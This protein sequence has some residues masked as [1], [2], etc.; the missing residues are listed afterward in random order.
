M[1]RPRRLLPPRDQPPVRDPERAEKQHGWVEDFNAV[2]RR[3]ISAQAIRRHL[4][5]IR[6]PLVFAMPAPTVATLLA[7]NQVAP[8]VYTSAGTVEVL[9]ARLINFHVKCASGILIARPYRL[10]ESV[11]FVDDG[12]APFIIPAGEGRRIPAPCDCDVVGLDV[13]RQVGGELTR[14]TIGVGLTP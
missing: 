13:M 3:D 14:Y 6:A 12:E 1:K 2:A 4:R 7:E 5:A 10:I 8:T 9:G 11:K